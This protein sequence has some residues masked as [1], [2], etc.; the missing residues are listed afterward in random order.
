MCAAGW[1]G[2]QCS[3]G[4]CV[5]ACERESVKESECGASA[6]FLKMS[7][8]LSNKE[9]AVARGN[10]HAGCSKWAASARGAERSIA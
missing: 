8:A 3:E 10:P 1:K 9:A 2:V 4:K 7:K 5:C 6:M